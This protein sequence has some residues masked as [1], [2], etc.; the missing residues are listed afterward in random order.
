MP[1]PA[2]ILKEA[3][4]PDGPFLLK[5]AIVIPEAAGKRTFARLALKS[6]KPHVQRVEWPKWTQLSKNYL[7]P[8]E[9]QP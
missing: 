3:L 4:A 6:S 2:D 9:L 7:I 5:E 1:P 8:V